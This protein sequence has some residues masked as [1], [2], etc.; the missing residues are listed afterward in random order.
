MV[1]EN[2]RAALQRKSGTSFQSLEAGKALHHARAR[3][4]LA[5]VN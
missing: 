3:E 2:V 4:L 1:L 5:E